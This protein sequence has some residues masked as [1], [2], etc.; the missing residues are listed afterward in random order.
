MTDGY[1]V[2]GLGRFGKTVA[3]TLADAGVQVMAVDISEEAVQ[4]IANEVTYAV[5]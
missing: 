4:D 5:V 1:A 2:L 3:L